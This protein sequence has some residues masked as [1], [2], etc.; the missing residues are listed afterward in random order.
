MTPPA[1]TQDEIDAMLRRA[2]HH[3]IVGKRTDSFD[4]EVGMF[5]GSCGPGQVSIA[6]WRGELYASATNC[7]P[8]DTSERVLTKDKVR[9]RVLELSA[10]ERAKALPPRCRTCGRW[11][12]ATTLGRPRVVCRVCRPANTR[13]L[14]RQ[15]ACGCGLILLSGG[16]ALF[17]T[18]ACRIRHWRKTR[19]RAV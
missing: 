9:T 15:C 4:W 10:I 7:V 2:F 16:K 12:A 14:M 18:S 13:H 17:A 8:S 6:L 3:T 19:N 11:M 5:L 1:W